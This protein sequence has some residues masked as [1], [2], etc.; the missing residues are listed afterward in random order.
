MM[1]RCPNCGGQVG[2]DAT[3]CTHCHWDFLALKIVPPGERLLGTGEIAETPKLPPSPPSSP[4]PTHTP[5]KS[6][7]SLPDVDASSFSIPALAPQDLEAAKKRVEA[8]DESFGAG[9]AMGASPAAASQAPE[10]LV[11]MGLD[12]FSR[13]NS[14]TARFGPPPPPEFGPALSQE[15]SASGTAASKPGPQA[16]QSGD[17]SVETPFW[18]PSPVPLEQAKDSRNPP[19]APVVPPKA[20]PQTPKTPAPASGAGA[21]PDV[22]DSRRP[23]AD[24]SSVQIE[25]PAV[26]QAPAAG[27]PKDDPAERFRKKQ[28]D[29]PAKGVPQPGS[30]RDRVMIAAIVLATIVVPVMI[31]LV[32]KPAPVGKPTPDLIV[33][34][35]APP[36]A[37]PD[38]PPPAQTPSAAP[39]VQAPAVPPTGKP[40]ALQPPVKPEP[41]AAKGTPSSQAQAVLHSP[42]GAA[43]KPAGP[44]PTPPPAKPQPAAASSAVAKPVPAQA[45]PPAAKEAPKPEPPAA[46]SAAQKVWAF[47]GRV[48]DVITLAP[49]YDAKLLLRDD[50][51]R[52]VG[53]AITTDEG[54]YTLTVPALAGGKYELTVL[55]QD[56]RPKYLDDIDPPYEEAPEVARQAVANSAP[57]NKPWVG[58]SGK[59]TVRDF[60]MVPASAQK[61]QAKP[62]PEPEPE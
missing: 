62:K 26:P 4:R 13:S 52:I 54:R 7:E 55:H 5:A 36:K 32:L 8:P 15:A 48:Y 9:L 24:P 49:V 10:S 34:E 11:S 51:G 60:V 57:R 56:Y 14:G 19:S 53:Q 20:I 40:P 21:L 2:E 30:S 12:A 25:W 50:S 38:H 42:E 27:K 3:R 45:P 1:C 18:V 37:A 23:V 43:A 17:A 58:A 35:Q 22:A 29:A 59:T 28:Q 16:S 31:Y 39:P 61:E 47:K 44:A 33:P 46:A 6:L 41:A